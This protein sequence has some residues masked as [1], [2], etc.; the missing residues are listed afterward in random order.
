MIGVYVHGVGNFTVCQASRD[1][2]SGLVRAQNHRLEE[3][4]VTAQSAGSNFERRSFYF[5]FYNIKL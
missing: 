5:T 2:S 3:K 1:T 4:N